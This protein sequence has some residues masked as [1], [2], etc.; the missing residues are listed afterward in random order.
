MSINIPLKAPWSFSNNAPRTG[1]SYVCRR[2]LL[3]EFLADRKARAS[4]VLKDAF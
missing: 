1:W 4:E 3:R 2:I